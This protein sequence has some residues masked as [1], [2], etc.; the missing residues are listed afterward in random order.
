MWLRLDVPTPDKPVVL[1]LTD[2]GMRTFK[3]EL[4]DETGETVLATGASKGASCQRLSHSFDTAGSYVVRV[5]L[6][7]GSGAGD[8]TFLAN[9]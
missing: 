8:F 6:T 7:G 3:L 9:Q 1:E 4:M 2:C 5:T